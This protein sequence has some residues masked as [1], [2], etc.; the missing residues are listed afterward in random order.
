[1]GMNAGAHHMTGVALHILSTLIL[2]LTLLRFTRAPLASGFAAAL[3]AIHPM[4]VESVAWISER[5]D[6]LSTLFGF[7]ALWAYASRSRS[8]IEVAALMAASLLSKQMLVT[9][10]VV[11]LV[12]DWWPLGRLRGRDDLRALVFEKIPLFVISAAAC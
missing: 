2:F 1:F 4:H 6:T 5:K 10:P 9:L 3:F 7:L 8:M 11:L 12:L